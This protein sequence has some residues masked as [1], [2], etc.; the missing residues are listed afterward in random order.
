MTRRR[1][2]IVHTRMPAFD[3]DSGSQDIDNIVRF[4]LRRGWRVTFLAR[5]DEHTAEQRHGDRLRAMGVE[6]HAGFGAL[7][8]LL[9]SN[10]FD[11]ALIAF[12]ELAVEVLPQ[13]RARSPRTRV[14][15]NSM[16]LHFLRNARRKFGLDAPLDATFGGEAIKEL[17]VYNA[18]DAV[19]AVSDK[20]R[21]LLADFLGE[22]RVFT[23]PLA[24]DVP[25]SPYPLSERHGMYFVGNFRHI[26]NREA[27]EYLA[28][29]VLPLLDPALLA[30][31]PLTVL[32]NWLDQIELDVTPGPGL[33]LVGWVPSIQPYIERSRLAAVPLLYGAGVKRKVMQAMMAGTPVVTTPVGAEGLDL[34]RGE[35]AL[36]ATDASDLAAGITRLLTDDDLWQRMADAAAEHVAGRHSV[37]LVERRFNEI[38][39]AVMDRRRPGGTELAPRARNERDAEAVRQ[40][41]QLLGRPGDVVLVATPPGVSVPEVGSHPIWPFP[42]AGDGGRADYEPVDGV[43]AVNH[44][45]M[46]R[47]RGARWFVLPR[48]AFRWRYR[49]PELFDKLEHTYRR[50][51]DDEH[52]T[53]F[54]LAGARPDAPVLARTPEA[55]VLVLGTYAAHRTGPPPTLVSELGASDTLTVE[56]VWQPETDPPTLGD[57]NADYVVHVRDDAILPSGF[58]D[59]LIATHETLAV[60]RVQPTHTA[61]P[62]GGPP[63]TERHFGTFA[64]EI[65][66]VTGLP[67]LSVRRGA[68]RRGP[69]VLADDTT[70]GLRQPLAPTDAGPGFVRR[71]WVLD[72]ERVP[73]AHERAEPAAPPRISVL[74]STYERPELLRSCVESFAEQTLDPS[75]FEVV[76]VDDGSRDVDLDEVLGDLARDLQLVTLR[77]D[78][79]GRSAAKNHA[80]MLARAP[81]V[82]FFDDDDRAAPDYLERHLAGHER[83]PGDGTAILGHTEW[84]PELERSALMHF[85][86]DVDRLMFS[87]GRMSDGQEL[88][89]RGFWEG[90][91]SCKRA[92]LMR[93]GLH[94]QRLAYSIDVEMGWRLSPAGLRVVYD[95]TARSFMARGID[96]DAFCDR[97]EAKGRAHAVIASLHVGSE[98]AE[99]LGIEDA[100]KVWEEGRADEARLRHRVA[101][102]EA[103]S[104]VFPDALPQ[105]HDA[106][107]AAFALL[108]AKGAASSGQEPKEMTGPPT[109]VHPFPNTDPEL[110][111]DATPEAHRGEPLLSITVPVWSRTPALAAMAQAT[112]DRIWEVARIPT[113]VV[114]VDNGS[115]Y[116]VPLAARVH[117]YPENKGVATG[118][119][120]GI[121]LSRAPMVVVLNSDCKVE[122]GWD[123]A[124]YEAAG[125]GRRVAFP[126]TDHCDGL[127]FTC[128]DQAGTAGWCFM[129]SKQLYDEIGVFD[130]WFNP[131]FC[132]DTDYWHRAWE[133]G[134]ELSPVPAARVVH[135]RRTTASTDPRVDMLLQ[136]HR[137]KY[138]WKHGVDPHRAPPY[139]NR[140][141]TDFVGTFRVPDPK[142]EARAGRP[143]V[144]GIGLNKT[145]TSSFHEAM[146][147]LGLESLHW[148][149]PMIRRLVETSL[150][151]GDP[152]LSRL[153][154]HYDAFSDIEV[155]SENFDLL[156]RQYPGSRFVL[157]VRPRDEWIASRRH[158][159]ETNLARRQ[160]GDYDGGFLAVDEEAWAAHWDEHV[161]R[162]REYFRGRDDFLELDLS[163]GADWSALCRLLGVEEPDE[164]FPWR[165]RAR[166]ED[167][168]A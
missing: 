25:R 141:Y 52:V 45:E 35:H 138:G 10:D 40:R 15:I 122:P 19:I 64:R 81:I 129:L 149:G 23:L 146:Q 158:H 58:L 102:L 86:T 46:Q 165:N 54:D 72:A 74:V 3:R 87:Y 22:G 12:W 53:V 21:D 151:A 150:E 107:R 69:V 96:F 65:D 49:Y 50:A 57:T 103:R 135:A 27:V 97:T 68:D 29:E 85:I 139:Y 1:A 14:V 140:E 4:L 145:G 34:V 47:Q 121:R 67:V 70:I 8:R 2:L 106:Y 134:V 24:E 83:N 43:A 82:L 6:T 156:D 60:D 166:R 16:D 152:L 80:V 62:S 44:L 76:V 18:A 28:D 32:G 163:K 38:L 11:L 48:P 66:E 168:L 51:Y 98:I 112:I 17:N 164:P 93:H 155:L 131:A 26:P 84:A 147:I 114:V 101:E 104:I 37:E 99:R 109:T 110:V 115:P 167:T 120:T 91:I 113:E 162:V 56:Q 90:R 59:A 142:V 117:R 137:Y 144:F 33:R 159:V 157:T 95:S 55:R 88:D 61:G 116:E 161:T 154:P 111:Y 7:E 124:L 148:G 63:V 132:E 123:V 94:D 100:A 92:L 42:Q 77:I 89:W 160:A 36:V 125:A 136:G 119:N 9:S 5:E 130:E 79:A 143:R 30:Q 75:E 31:H 153:D 13:L 126:Y 105:L 128:P 78:H 71:T 73:A 108:H 41:V 39:E 133:V 20:E 118:W 127:G